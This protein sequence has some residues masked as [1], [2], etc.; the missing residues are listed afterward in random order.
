VIIIK[1]TLK[2]IEMIKN[3]KRVLGHVAARWSGLL[4]PYNSYEN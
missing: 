3:D 4:I 2:K 1:N